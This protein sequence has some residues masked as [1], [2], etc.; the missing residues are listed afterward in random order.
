MFVKP[1]K[2]LSATAA[3]C[4][5]A[6]T[7]GSLAQPAPGTAPTDSARNLAT[8][9]AGHDG[10]SDPAPPAVIFANVHYVGTCGITALL[11]TSEYGH[12]LIDGATEKAAPQIISNI[13]K[14]GF[15]PS[16]VRIL[17]TSHEH[18]DHVGGVAEL[19]RRTGAKLFARKE[20]VAT[21][22]SGMMD[23]QDP[24]AGL[25]PS[26]PAARVDG[27]VADGEVVRLGPLALTVHATT[28]H[29]SGSTSWSWTS[30]NGNDCRDIVYADSLTAV[31]ADGYRFSDHPELVTDFHASFA[32][33][34]KLP[35]ELLLT[36]HPGASGMFERFSGATPFFDSNACT[37]YAVSAEM[38][39][40]KRLMTEQE[41]TDDR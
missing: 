13:E 28:G 41:Q 36:P 19:Q 10:W 24:Q 40:D 4:A 8:I 7:N 18:L 17:L 39:L 11:I 1:A 14:L 34:A 22:E 33:L 21:L 12:I 26:F 15:N 2:I 3:L 23:A 31:S 38:R 9:C 29:S 16:D 35:C 30:C 6:M 25:H 32:K 27:I 5:L 20:A 37:N